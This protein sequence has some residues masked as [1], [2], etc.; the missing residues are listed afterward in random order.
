MFDRLESVEEK[1]RKLEE[2]L[3]NPEILANQK[4]YRRIARERAEIAPVVETYRQYKAL[5]QQIGENQELLEEE[6]DPEMRE[7]VRHEIGDLREK[8]QGIENELKFML[9]PRDPNDEEKRHPTNPANGR[10]RSG[11]LCRRPVPHV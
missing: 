8:L 3:S 2:D 7:L 4:E 1:Y 5:K 11:T 6:P 9:A 10:R